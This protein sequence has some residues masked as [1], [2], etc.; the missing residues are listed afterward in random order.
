MSSAATHPIELETIPVAQPRPDQELN[1]VGKFAVWWSIASILFF[2]QIAYNIGD[3]PVASDLICY[4]FFTAFLLVSRHAAVSVPTLYLLTCTI[5]LS[6][7]RIPFSSSQSSL[8]SL[9]LLVA[10]YSPFIFRLQRRPDIG[11]VHDYI[12]KAYVTAATVIAAVAVIQIVLVNITKLDVLTNIYFILPKDIRGAGTYTFLREEGGIVKANGFFLRE[13]GELSAVTALALLIEYRQLRRLGVMIALS[14]GLLTSLSGSGLIVLAAG[15]LLP[16]SISRI[17]VFVVSAFGAFLLLY[18]LYSLELPG[19]DRW[20]GRLSEFTTPNT[21]GYA[22]FVAP[23][24][25]IRIGFDHGAWA[26]W[27]GNGPGSFFRDVAIGRFGYEVSDPTWA[28]LTYEYGLAGLILVS[29]IV[30]IRLYSSALRADICNFYMFSWV[31]FPYV[32][33]PSSAL[34]I[35]LITLVPSL[36]RK[37]SPGK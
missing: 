14:M 4:A 22:R 21:S 34:V 1:S 19:L 24:E 6:L 17:P 36:P 32:L 3:F 12:L 9:L 18:T 16:R 20:F 15:L 2:N 7:L 37:S 5:A 33:K 29:A 28:K 26:T 25:M 10:G 31:I 11:Y 30:A 13:S 23:W 27:L 8:S 35:W